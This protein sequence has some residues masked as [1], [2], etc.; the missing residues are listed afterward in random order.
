M[1]YLIY[2]LVRTDGEIYIGTTSTKNLKQRM[3][4]HGYSDRF[5]NINDFKIEI[6]FCGKHI[7]CWDLEEFFIAEYDSFENG[8]NESKDGKG[9]H[10][11]SKFTTLGYK[12][13]KE[14][15]LKIG[16]KSKLKTPWNLGK[17]YKLKPGYKQRKGKIQSKKISDDDVI[18]I[19]KSFITDDTI[20]NVGVVQKNGIKMTRERAFARKYA[21]KFNVSEQCIIKYLKNETLR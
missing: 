10:L 11:S 21:P 2:K 5:E 6:I 20:L 18:F 1:I 3:H 9:N 7:T 13:S 17:T 12:H 4:H 8:L 15:K 16:A 14:T 19:R